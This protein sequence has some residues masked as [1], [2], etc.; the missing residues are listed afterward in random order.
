M[1]NSEVVVNVVNVMNTWA[2]ILIGLA[3]FLGIFTRIAQLAGMILL[4]TFYI[5]HPPIF[6]YAPIAPEKTARDRSVD[7]ALTVRCCLIQCYT[8]HCYYGNRS[9]A[10]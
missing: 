6:T 2:L 1:G 4:F 9:L 3:L 8:R 10:L 5:S 7:N